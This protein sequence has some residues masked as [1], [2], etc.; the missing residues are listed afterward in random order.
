MLKFKKI[1][2]PKKYVLT[3]VTIIT[4]VTIVVTLPNRNQV[5]MIE[6]GLGY[7]VVPIQK[8]LTKIQKW[9]NENIF[10][11]FHAYELQDKNAKLVKEL[12]ELRYENTIL[13]QYKQDNERLRNLLKLDQKYPEYPKVGAQVIGK[14]PGNWY[15]M[16]LIDKGTNHGLAIDMVVMADSGLVGRIVEVGS[17]YAKVLSIID[18]TSSVSAQTLRTNE[19]AII[20]GDKTLMDEGLCRIQHI[21]IDAQIV[22]GDEMVTSHLGDLYPPGILIGTITEIKTESNGLTKYGLL[23]PAVDFQHLEE[24]LVIDKPWKGKKTNLKE[25]TQ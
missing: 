23:E 13:Q 2:I 5:T 10:F 21:N 16:F 3:I 14:D 7:V 4:M 1:L 9:S 8:I 17:N 18:D 22:K 6:N 24:V 11:I 12:D 20:R 15:N 25:S 19:V